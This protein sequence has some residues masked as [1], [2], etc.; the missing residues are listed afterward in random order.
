MTEAEEKLWFRL[1]HIKSSIEDQMRIHFYDTQYFE[2]A[3]KKMML[4][5]Q[6]YAIR[7]R[8]YLPVT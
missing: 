2:L 3:H 5:D 8:N 6:M 1:F 4:E 7:P